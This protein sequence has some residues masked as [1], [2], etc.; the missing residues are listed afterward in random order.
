MIVHGMKKNEIQID[1]YI[2]LKSDLFA[3]LTFI[4]FL[5]IEVSD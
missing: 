5:N 3:P 1:I 2:V 4:S